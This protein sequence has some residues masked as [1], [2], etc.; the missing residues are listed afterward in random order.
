MKKMLFIIVITLFITEIGYSQ[1]TVKKTHS[2]ITTLDGKTYFKGKLFNGKIVDKYKG[3]KLKSE[4]PYTDGVLD[5]Y[6][7]TYFPEYRDSVG[8][9]TGTN[10]KYMGRLG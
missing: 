8:T 10:F 2:K 6:V 5:G 3:G 4:E 9:D 1:K 7:I